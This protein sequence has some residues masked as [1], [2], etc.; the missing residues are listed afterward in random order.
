VEGH[1]VAAILGALEAAGL[2]ERPSVVLARTTM[3]RGL[4]SLGDGRDA[5]FI[6]LD[7]G[8][9]DRAL[10]DTALADT[11]LYDTAVGTAR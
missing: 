7:P 11:A 8:D 9:V 4:G 6:T 1:G 3:V 10:A 5:H 2:S